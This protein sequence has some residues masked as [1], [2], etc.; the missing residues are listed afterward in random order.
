MGFFRV[1]RL[2]FLPHAALR[3]SK[4]LARDL[5]DSDVAGEEKQNDPGSGR[6]SGRRGCGAEGRRRPGS[7]AWQGREQLG[8]R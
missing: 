4:S 3:A 7:G 1:D 5:D 2:C 6:R 8:D